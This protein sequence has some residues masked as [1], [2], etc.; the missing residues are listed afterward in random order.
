MSLI[1]SE[2]IESGLVNEVGEGKSSGGRPP[3]VLRLDDERNYVVGV[4][5]MRHVISLAVTDLRAEVLTPR[6]STWPRTAVDDQVRCWTRCAAAVEDAARKA[7]VRLDQV[8]GI[9]I[10]L[11]GLV[12]ADTGVCRYSPSFGWRD[13][14]VA[15][16]HYAEDSGGRC[17]ST[18]T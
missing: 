14:P 8:V 15:A 11:A 12:D 17:W 1:V 9:G 4:K 7:G 10:G 5:L 3:L 18:T 13:V 6:W 16:A 2:L